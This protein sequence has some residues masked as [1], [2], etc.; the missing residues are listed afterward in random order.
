MI[1]LSLLFY[2]AVAVLLLIYYAL[3]PRRRWVA[4]L[5]GSLGIYYCFSGKGILFLGTGIF[6]SYCSGLLMQAMRKRG[7]PRLWEK[8]CLAAGIIAVMAPLLLVKRG[9]FAPGGAFPWQLPGIAY[10]TLQAAGY[11]VDVYRRE[12]APEKNPAKYA[13]F[14]A[15]F[16]QL[17]QGPIARYGQ[18]QPQFFAGNLFEPAKFTRGVQRIIWGFFLKMMIADRAG[19]IVCTVFDN[20]EIYTG[21]Y[22]LAAGILYSV[23]LYADFMACVYIARGIALLF[24]I[25]LVD[26]FAHPYFSDSIKEFWGRWHISLSS[27]LRDYVYIPLGGNRKGKFRTYI[28]IGITFVASGM[29]HGSGYKYIVWG[30]MHAMYQI[31]GDLTAKGRKSLYRL[32]GMEE[33]ELAAHVIKKTLVFFQV[34][35]AWIIF[36]AGSL[37]VGI[38]MLVSLFTVRNPWIFFDDS[39]FALGLDIKECMIL[40]LAILL[41]LAVSYKQ[42]RMEMPMGEWLLRQHILLRW[43][44]YLAAIVGIVVFGMYG[45][46]FDARDFIYGGF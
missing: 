40:V 10:Y 34:M 16:P 9:Y 35:L 45:Y 30:L 46:G 22:V 7:C 11:M 5:A 41:L 42:S 25:G 26:N 12:L 32:V 2:F 20:W 4:L 38:R 14:I 15:F 1:F 44:I 29:W 21:G 17:V 18:L 27:W 23:Q 24:G 13:L 28:N 8:I 3:P 43:G 39:L 6:A 19:V 31:V 37:R 36:R 33:T